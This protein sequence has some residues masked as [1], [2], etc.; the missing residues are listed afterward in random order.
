MTLK[1]AWRVRSAFLMTKDVASRLSG[2]VKRP[3]E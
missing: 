3:G 2:E 1:A